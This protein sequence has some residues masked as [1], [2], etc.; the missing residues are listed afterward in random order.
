MA[1]SA[2]F[3]AKRSECEENEPH[4]QKYDSKGPQKANFQ[5]KSNNEE[6]QS[7]GNHGAYLFSGATPAASHSTSPVGQE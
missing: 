5:H 4:E 2:N 1:S 3:V 6:N 7:Q